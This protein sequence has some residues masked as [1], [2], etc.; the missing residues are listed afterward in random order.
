MV[1]DGRKVIKINESS[2][3]QIRFFAIKEIFEIEYHMFRLA[4]CANC[5]CPHGAKL[6]VCHGQDDSVVSLLLWR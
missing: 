4:E 6:P 5:R 3:P 2:Q 1:W